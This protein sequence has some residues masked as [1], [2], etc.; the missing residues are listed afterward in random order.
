MQHF[1]NNTLCVIDCETT[2]LDPDVH[3]IIELCV[4]PLDPRYLKPTADYFRCYIRP[5]NLSTID[6]KTM[7][8]NKLQLDRLI[9]Y[10]KSTVDVL[11]AFDAWFNRVVGVNKYGTKCQILPLGHNYSFD[12]NFLMRLF[13]QKLYDIYFHYHTR[14]TQIAAC[15][16]N[17]HAVWHGEQGPFSKV[18]LQWL[19]KQFSIET[20][21][22]HTALEDC[23]TVSLIYKAM[24]SAGIFSFGRK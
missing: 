23:K 18:N 24:I 15:F 3:E 20:T 19:A 1:N 10:G 22:A 9:K 17:D 6:P 4:M 14:D 5:E 11:D 16:M 21:N 13:G 12:K 2:G 8:V 7:T